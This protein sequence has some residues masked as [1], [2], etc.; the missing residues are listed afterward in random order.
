MTGLLLLGT[1][2][3]NQSSFSQSKQDSID[4]NFEVCLDTSFSSYDML[5]FKEDALDKWE[6]K[7]NTVYDSILNLSDST[8]RD[9]LIKSQDAWKKYYDNE[10]KLLESFDVPTNTSSASWLYNKYD[11]MIILLKERILK[12]KDLEFYLD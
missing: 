7:L 9:Y 3:V 1:L 6:E 8:H 10:V 5:M 12:L 2:L 11:R 4:I